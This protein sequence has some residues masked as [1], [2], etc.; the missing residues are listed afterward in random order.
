MLDR[1]RALV[2]DIINGSVKGCPALNG[3]CCDAL[4]LRNLLRA[5]RDSSA[6]P[7]PS[8]PYLGLA[9][10]SLAFS[11]RSIVAQRECVTADGYKDHVSLT[12]MIETK[13]KDAETLIG[14]LRLPLPVYE[15]DI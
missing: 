7:L 8:P 3:H 2:N 15:D 1:A 5:L 9:F 6:W 12:H 4:F 11:L 13:L 14:N 10:W